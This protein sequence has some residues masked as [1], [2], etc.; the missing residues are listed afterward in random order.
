M[1]TTWVS[2]VPPPPIYRPRGLADWW[3]VARRG[4]PMAA[5]IGIG[6]VVLMMI[7]LVE[8][9]LYGA[10]RPLSPHVTVMV[11]RATIW[12]IGIGRVVRG[13]P[14][15]RRGA[16]V[17]NHVAWLDVFMLN[18][19]R[20]LYFVAK[21]EVAKWPGI[22]FLARATG[23]LFIAR[24]R[25]EAKVQQDLFRSRLLSGHHLLFFPEGTSTDSCRVLPFKPTLFA[26]FFD[27]ALC[28]EMH[29][30]PI[31][32]VYH[33]PAGG[34]PRFYGWWGDMDFGSHLLAMLA[35]RKHGWAE[36]I[37]HDPVRVD[38]FSNRKSLALDLEQT[39][40]RALEQARPVAKS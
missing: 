1:T 23:T 37:F 16:F 13:R 20:D 7:R 26:A 32:L 34:D 21:S 39:V 17:A 27:E 19:A 36:V 12:L 10:R 3:R 5:V 22:G 38:D 4:V 28:H 29:I 9:P 25:R 2:D 11:C 8:W 15:R 18:S 24:A 14:M 31:T 35:T 33:A 40:R 30:Q 6:V